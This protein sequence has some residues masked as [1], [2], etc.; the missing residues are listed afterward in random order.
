MTTGYNM[1]LP[2]PNVSGVAI[3][4]ALAVK[5]SSLDNYKRQLEIRR[6]AQENYAAKN[7]QFQFKDKEKTP[8]AVKFLLATGALVAA[9][10]G[11]KHLIKNFKK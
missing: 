7:K 1:Q 11:A 9:F 10:F 6:I 3:P 8:R 4:G 2:P 5:K